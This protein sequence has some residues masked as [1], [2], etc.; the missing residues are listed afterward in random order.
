MDIV[1][2]NKLD[3]FDTVKKYNKILLVFFAAIIIYIIAVVFN[4]VF[5]EIMPVDSFLA[6]HT[7]FEFASILVSFSIFTVAYFIYEESGDLSMIIFGCAFLSMSFLDIFHTLSYKGMP[8]FFIVNDT[9]NRATVLWILSRTSGTL[10]FMVASFIPRHITCKIKKERF[11]LVTSIFSILLFLIT[12]YSPNFFPL[13]FVDG[14]GLTSIKIFIEYILI[15]C[16]II[17]FIRFAIIHQR[18]DSNR[19]YQ[20]MI[21]LV[22]LAFSEFAFTNYGS[23]YDAFNYIGHFFKVIAY[24]ILYKAVYVENLT[25]PYKQLKIAK[26]KLKI[27]SNNLDLL[28]EKRTEE[29]KDLNEVLLEDIEYAKEMQN[30]LLPEQMPKDMSVTFDAKFFITERLSGDFYNVIKLDKDNIALYIGDVSG[31]G[32]SAAM[33]TVF[34][35][36]NVIQLK[37]HKDS[38]EELIKPGSVLKT[39]F[40]SFNKTNI[41]SE[42]YILMLYCIYNTKTKRLTYSSAGINTP[43]YI[44]RKSGEVIEIDVSGLPICKL[45]DLIDPT[46]ENKT[47]ELKSGDKVLFY[48]DGLTEAMDEN[49][50][51]YGQAKLEEFLKDNYKLNAANLNDELTKNLLDYIGPGN[52]LTDD[53]TLLVMELTK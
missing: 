21:A 35:N 14:E 26:D 45:G 23:A 9:A 43:P 15:F 42:K 28:V 16:L 18:T 47:V 11:V 46:Y 8:D 34:A 12:T 33:L 17:T 1:K 44:I 30:W 31:H 13:M 48:S 19:D 27:Y 4:N 10:G 7:I 52:E 41:N 50:E 38:S 32:V 53:T 3:L 6:W 5:V 29:L 49:K 39:V 24:I 20:F 40:N 51:E 37:E 25:K 22:L 36:Q 2:T